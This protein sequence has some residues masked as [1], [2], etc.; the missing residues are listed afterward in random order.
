MTD[1]N[2]NSSVS[3]AIAAS[4]DFVDQQNAG[5]FIDRNIWTFLLST[6]PFQNLH[7]QTTANDNF[8]T[9]QAAG[10]DVHGSFAV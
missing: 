7:L 2:F 9:W 5:A 8:A 1:N 4:I 6:T 10:F 3:N